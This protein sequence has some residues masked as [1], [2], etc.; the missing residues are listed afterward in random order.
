MD[1]LDY[2]VQAEKAA[3]NLRYAEAKRL[4]RKALDLA[5]AGR[6]RDDLFDRMRTVEM[7]EN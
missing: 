7:E 2:A 5:P 4:Y 3:Y 1:W 6:T